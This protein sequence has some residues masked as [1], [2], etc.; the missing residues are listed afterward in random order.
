MQQADP[1]NRTDRRNYF[2]IDDVTILYHRVLANDEESHSQE[3]VN[4]LAIDRL[5]LK[6]RFEALTRELKPLSSH[7]EQGNPRLAQYLAAIDK[8]LN[9]LSEVLMD[10]AV[11][12]LDEKPQ[13]V[14]ISA[15]G[16]SFESSSPI[17][18]GSI[19]ELRIILLPTN[20]GIYSHARVVLCKKED[21]DGEGN[22][23]YKIAVEFVRMD[24]EFRDLI[25]RHVLSRERAA[26]V[27]GHE[28]R[29]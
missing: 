4:Q 11:D 15:G 29:K 14:N 13:K 12:D 18:P 19:L 8:K 21:E 10:A 20:V 24:E 25:S 27:S 2:R 28:I 16:L 6:A 3:E 9:M 23:M 5:T 1:E 7:I 17:T 22:K 26:L